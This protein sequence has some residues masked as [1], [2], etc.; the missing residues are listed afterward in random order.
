MAFF[1]MH[2]HF[3]CGVDDGAKDE[4]ESHKLLRMAYEDGTRAICLTP[5]FN[6]YLFGDTSAA[7][8][9]AFERLREYAAEEFPDLELYLGHELG[10]YD[11]CL[12]ALGEGRC[13]TLSGSRYLL[14]DFP[15]GVPFSTL[16]QGTDRLLQ[17][18]YTPVLAHAE[19]YRAL[20]FH[21]KWLYEFVACG[22]L[23][24]LN[25]GNAVGN[26]GKFEQKQFK[27]IVQAN[28]AHVVSSDGH[29]VETRKPLMSVC[30]P[31]LE[32]LV[33][34]ETIRRLTWENARAIV[35]NERL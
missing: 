23:V 32:N 13:R 30:L 10:Y 16:R 19:R 7:S 25:A 4:H 29:N 24:Q 31:V 14:V 11:S 33:G 8:E 27:K 35:H 12:S 28:L 21:F 17:M 22:G 26:F 18:G 1:D 5:H 3:L 15:A 34:P 20:G 2:T 9:R 6:P